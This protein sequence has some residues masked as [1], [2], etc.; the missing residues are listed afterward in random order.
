MSNFCALSW[1]GEQIKA[2][3]N[4][5]S[6]EL[7]KKAFFFPACAKI[8]HTSHLADKGGKHGLKI[9]FAQLRQFCSVVPI[10]FYVY[11]YT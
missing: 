11:Y 4:E 1:T 8:D 7:V 10:L 3:V 2:P 6:G 5:S 9:L